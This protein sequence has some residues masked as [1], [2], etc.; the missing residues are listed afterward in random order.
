MKWPTLLPLVIPRFPVISR[1]TGQ[2][3]LTGREG[4]MDP[5]LDAKFGAL[6]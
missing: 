2:E 1:K 4:L 3:L 6:G 5:A